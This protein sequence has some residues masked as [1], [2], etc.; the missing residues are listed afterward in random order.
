MENLT[1]SNELIGALFTLLFTCL[2]L[3]VLYYIWMAFR[4]KLNN[5][6]MLAG[7]ASFFIFGYLLSG[8]L[9][10]TFAPEAKASELGIL[11]YA[12]RRAVCVAVTEA[13]GIWISLY[14][15]YKKYNTIRVPTGFGLGFQLFNLLYL[16]GINGFIRLGY[17]MSVNKNG[18]DTVLS[19]VD[20]QYASRFETL[21]RDLAGTDPYIFIMSAVDY[22]CMFLITVALTRILWYSIEGG[23]KES[24]K[25]LILL[26]FILR[27][28]AE[29]PLAMYQAGAGSYRLYAIIYY[30]ITAL[31]VAFA[32]WL[33]KD[34]DDKEQIR[35]ER[36]R[37]R[38]K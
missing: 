34:R 26:A 5:I 30:V 27:L 17:A 22:V 10:G 15:L 24:S 33:S 18:L 1:F 37:A 3:P 4:K 6:A 21:L 36:L 29:V 25:L 28:A 32:V 7:I 23:K 9:L 12:L 19:S 35:S 20:P 2:M 38:R 16:G 8:F 31:I 11:G 13:G 14:L